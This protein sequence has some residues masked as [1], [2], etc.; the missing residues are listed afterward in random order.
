MAGADS[1]NAAPRGPRR[2]GWKAALL[3][4]I[5]VGL[6]YV[7][8]RQLGGAGPLLAAVRDARPEWVAASFGLTCICLALGVQRWR[9]VLAA[10]GH[11]L[12]FWRGLEVVL[13]T[14][15][16]TVVAPSR[17]NEFLRP[18][19]LRATI[20]LF[21]GTGSVLAEKAADVGLLLGLA[22]AGCAA[23]GMWLWAAAFAGIAA[24]E[25]V[26]VVAIV[27]NRKRVA[28]LPL[29]RRRA[30]Q[31]DQIFEAFVALRRSPAH[32]AGLAFTSLTIRALTCV[33][34]Y[35]LLLAFRADVGA[36]EALTR[37]PAAL[38]M[39][40]V[41]VTMAGMGTRDAAF[42]VLLGDAGV[43]AASQPA[44]LA[45]TMGYSA[46]A[47]WSFAVVGLPFMIRE[48]LH[49]RHHAARQGA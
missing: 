11:R 37:W 24:A 13:A 40:L 38:L 6:L 17:A 46:I 30:E 23:A 20:P 8:I 48:A 32:A 31:I 26:V 14:W 33:I 25:V 15:P 21:A 42:V 47:V 7:L 35:T 12:S 1:A 49:D 29:L 43:P 36:F 5:T 22:A 3:A 39:G 19:A 27:R 4:A 18:F 45:A 2:I 28:A 10:M 9:I 34:A 16:L 41:P 44:I